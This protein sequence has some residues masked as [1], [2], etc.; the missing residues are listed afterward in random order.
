MRRRYK[1][2]RRQQFYDRLR[3]LGTPEALTSAKIFGAIREAFSHGYNRDKMPKN[4][5]HKTSAAW[6]AFCAGKDSAP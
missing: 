6:I 1:D 3:E 5:Y 2:P 4:R